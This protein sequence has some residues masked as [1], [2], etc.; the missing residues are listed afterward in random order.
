[1][2]LRLSQ[3]EVRQVLAIWMDVPSATAPDPK[4]WIS[5]SDWSRSGNSVSSPGQLRGRR[6]IYSPRLG[7]VL[8]QAPRLQ[9][10]EEMIAEEHAGI[11][12]RENAWRQEQEINGA[13]WES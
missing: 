10:Y 11:M 3:K 4:I 9:T 2:S 5:L 8:L 12:R 7:G 13:L 6:N 1:M